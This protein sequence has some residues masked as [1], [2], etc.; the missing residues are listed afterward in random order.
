[1]SLLIPSIVPL[2]SIESPLQLLVFDVRFEDIPDVVDMRKACC[3][4]V[5][6]DQ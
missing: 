2:D 1:M 3:S 4:D 5:R 6:F